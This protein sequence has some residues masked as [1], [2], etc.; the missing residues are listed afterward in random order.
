MTINKSVIS[1][2]YSLGGT[3]VQHKHSVP[4]AGSGRMGPRLDLALWPRSNQRAQATFQCIIE[5]TQDAEKR[6]TRRAQR[7]PQECK[8]LGKQIYD[9]SR[10]ADPMER[11]RCKDMRAKLDDLKQEGE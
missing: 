4:G 5:A 11:A 1:T 7:E 8:N 10:S 6:K 9:L 2:S 3:A